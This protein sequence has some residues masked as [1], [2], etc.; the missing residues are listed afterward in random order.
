MFRRIDRNIIQ[1][2]MNKQFNTSGY[3]N[4][5]TDTSHTHTR[6]APTNI[7]RLV[8]NHFSRLLE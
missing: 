3:R 4:K 6:I 2:K 8:Q 7:I 1:Y 5:W